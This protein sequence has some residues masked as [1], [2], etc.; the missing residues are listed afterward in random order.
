MSLFGEKVSVAD[1]AASIGDHREAIDAVITGRFA[2]RQFSTRAVPREIVEDVLGVARFCPSGGNIQ[3]WQVYVVTGRTK[4]DV[5][6]AL[7]NAHQQ[8]PESHSSEYAYYAKVLPEPYRSRKEEFGRIFYGALGIDQK[9]TNR[10]ALQTS[11]N[12]EFFGAPVGLIV[13]IDRRLEL[14]SW[15]DLGMFVQNVMIAA[16]ARGL[17]TCPQ[18]TFAKYHAILRQHLPIPDEQMVACGMSIGFADSGTDVKRSVMPKVPVSEFARF[19]GFT[20]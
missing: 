19:L 3:P 8:A 6:A 7:L 2:S 12:Y 1:P 10:R 18:E 15:L 14:G 17:Q 9:D 16:G 5:S 13:T 11:K 4:E 20:G